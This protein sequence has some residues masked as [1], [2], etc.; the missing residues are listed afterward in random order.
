M[1]NL[2]D[3]FKNNNSSELEAKD[4]EIVELTRKIIK[5]NKKYDSLKVNSEAALAKL[6]QELFQVK[7]AFNE[8]KIQF[9]DEK[10]LLEANIQN[11][12]LE[13]DAKSSKQEVTTNQPTVQAETFNQTYTSETKTKQVNKKILF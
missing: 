6:N 2:K 10:H 11:L 7:N 1:D 5:Q 12:K 3:K 9:A 13:L 4:K 8:T